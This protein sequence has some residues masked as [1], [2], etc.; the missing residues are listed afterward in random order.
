[1]LALEAPP[2]ALDWPLD[3]GLGEADGGINKL[4]FIFL[5][6]SN[7]KLKLFKLFQRSFKTLY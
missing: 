4:I 3:Y 2:T 5:F 6:L 7:V 1:M